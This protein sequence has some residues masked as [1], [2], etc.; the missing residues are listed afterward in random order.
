VG[1][2][3]P[4]AAAVK[5][6][7]ERRSKWNKQEERL[8]AIFGHGASFVRELASQL[9]RSGF[10]VGDGN[11]VEQHGHVI[12]TQANQVY[13]QQNLPPGEAPGQN[14]EAES[15]GEEDANRVFSQDKLITKKNNV[16]GGELSEI[17]HAQKASRCQHQV[18]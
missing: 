14:K 4:S 10:F 8:T 3:L 5:Q 17:V 13:P 12:E 16:D 6:S 1:C 11:G 9:R 7:Q 18:T 2:F 15:D